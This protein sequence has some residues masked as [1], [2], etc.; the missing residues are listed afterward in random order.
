[1]KHEKFAETQKKL[2]TIGSYGNLDLL[3]I[4]D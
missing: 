1:M 2:K 4:I 3:E